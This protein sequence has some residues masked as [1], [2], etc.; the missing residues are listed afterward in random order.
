MTPNA[1]NPDF[2]GLLQ[3]F[4][5]ERMIQQRNPSQR[6]VASYRD[7][8]RLLLLFLE[9][10]RKK[11]PASLRMEDLEPETIL[12][13]LD[14]L[15]KD[16][17]NS[18]R[19][20]NARLAAIRAFLH[21][22]AGYAPEH[23]STIQ[24]SLAIPMKRFDR[25][26]VGYLSRPEMEAVLDAPPTS[27]WRGRR[28]RMLLTTLYNTGARVSEIIAVKVRDLCLGNS[29]SVSLHGKGRKERSLPL[30]KS[31]ARQL[32]QWLREIDG[33]PDSALFPNA[34]G[35]P[36][37]RSGV[38]HILDKAVQKARARCPSLKSR[39]VS[40]HIIRHSTAMHLL[41]SGVDLTVI[42]LWL[43]HESPST[44]H[45]Y[46]EADLTMKQKALGALAEPA[47]V[48]TPRFRASDKLLQFLESL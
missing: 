41:Q 13:F 11:T 2:P 42:A 27:T 4:F 29:C 6:T 47:A 36:L 35:K 30:W 23:L 3:R 24:R 44:T 32:S 1:A 26:L 7:T 28:D 9:Q 33:S 8:F 40:P 16:R 10:H 22:A 34:R 48:H 20:R 46:V 39:R 14:Y 19:S 45:M 25:R 43:G 5:C 37:S 15:E 18:I 21:Y 17:K 38:E 12:A 31:T